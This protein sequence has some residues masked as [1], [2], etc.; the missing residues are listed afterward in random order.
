[1]TR[2]QVGGAD[3]LGQPGGGTAELWLFPPIGH[4]GHI[5]LPGA[6]TVWQTDVQEFLAR[7]GM[8]RHPLLFP[9]T[10]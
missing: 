1:M 6:V 5:L 7:I 2:R 10:T 4:D 8:P 9:R 3:R